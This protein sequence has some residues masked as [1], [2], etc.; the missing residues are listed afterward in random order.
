M[1]FLNPGVIQD[2]YDAQDSDG[3]LDSLDNYPADAPQIKY[4]FPRVMHVP[5]L[6][7]IICDHCE[8][9]VLTKLSMSCKFL[10]KML[11]SETHEK[12]LKKGYVFLIHKHKYSVAASRLDRIHR[13]LK[14][15]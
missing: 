9:S 3:D 7:Y 13:S 1:L 2:T 8:P 6:A 4:S 10:L 11:T 5:D 12:S 15:G 14:T